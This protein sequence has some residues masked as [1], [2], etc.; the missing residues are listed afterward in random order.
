MMRRARRRSLLPAGIIFAARHCPRL[1][2]C[3]AAHPRLPTLPNPL[4]SAQ[5]YLRSLVAPHAVRSSL[6]VTARAVRSSLLVQSA[7]CCSCRSLV[8]ARA[9]RPSLLVPGHNRRLVATPAIVVAT[10]FHCLPAS[11]PF[12]PHLG[13]SAALHPCSQSRRCTAVVVA[14]ATAVVVVIVAAIDPVVCIAAAAFAFNVAAAAFSFS[15]Y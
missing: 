13:V 14:I 11:P 2:S 5:S 10:H 9:V 8:A 12:R 3:V 1:H 6:F 4:V 7:C 15:S